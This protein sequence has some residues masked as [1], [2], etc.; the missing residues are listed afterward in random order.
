MDVA[1]LRKKVA[2]YR[3]I[4]VRAIEPARHKYIAHRVKVEHDEVQA[5]F[6]GGKVRELWRLVTFLYALYLA[7]WEQYHNGRKPILR[8]TRYSVKT[9]FDAK[10]Q[11]SAPHEA[12]VA[13]TKKLMQFIETA[14]PNSKSQ[15]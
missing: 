8:P 1:R 2:D 13:E 3:A 10:E 9:I 7:L 14:T 11:G 4:Y 12:I 15:T 5:L 6:A